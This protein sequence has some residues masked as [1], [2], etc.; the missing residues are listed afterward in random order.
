MGSKWGDGMPSPHFSSSMRHIFALWSPTMSPQA[1]SPLLHAQSRRVLETDRLVLRRPSLADVKAIALMANDRR[2]AEQTGRLPHPY[3]EA[4]AE[5]F[6]AAQA[7][8]EALFLIE[9]KHEHTALGMIGIDLSNSAAP[10]LGYWLGH[11]HWGQGYASEAARAVITYV[12]A[13][14]EA[15]ALMAAARVTNEASRGVLE[16]C[17]FAWTG[18]GLR[19]FRALGYSAP[20]D[21]FALP[22]ARWQERE[23]WQDVR[24]VA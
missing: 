2:V 18:V 9:R 14:S 15:E 23:C 20:V 6:I 17:G 13:T 4:D 19:R 1:T 22:R 5:A 12:F 7:R 24:D 11:R 10:E 16:S 8:D 3:R 21:L